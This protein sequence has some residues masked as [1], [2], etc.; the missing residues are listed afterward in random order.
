MIHTVFCEA[1]GWQQTDDGLDHDDSHVYKPCPVEDCTKNAKRK[2]CFV[3]VAAVVWK[4]GG[5]TKGY[6]GGKGTGIPDMTKAVPNPGHSEPTLATLGLSASD[7]AK[8]GI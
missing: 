1:H 5:A 2:D 7:G 8:L 3:E 4:C 6:R